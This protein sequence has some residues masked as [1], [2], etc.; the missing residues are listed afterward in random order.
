[1]CI[2]PY[3]QFSNLVSFFTYKSVCFGSSSTTILLSYRGIWNQGWWIPS[4]SVFVAMLC[5]I[6]FS[7]LVIIAFI[8]NTFR[9]L[10]QY[11]HAHANTHSAGTGNVFLLFS[12]SSYWFNGKDRRRHTGRKNEI[13]WVKGRMHQNC[14]R[15]L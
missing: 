6:P 2:V 13:S 1:M 7:R 3:T 12:T 9:F 8:G 4:K 5:V 10:L 15:C 11:T 14:L